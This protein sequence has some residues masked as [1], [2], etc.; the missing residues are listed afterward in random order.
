MNKF[1]KSIFS[2]RF[3]NL[4][5][6][7]IAVD[8][9]GG[10]IYYSFTTLLVKTDLEG[11]LVGTVDGLIGHLGCI[12]YNKEDGR[13][14]GSLE[15]KNDS[16]GR[17]IL[18]TLGMEGKFEDAFYC[19]IFDVERIDCVGM[20]A[21]RDGVMRAVYLSEVVADYNGI[22]EDSKP[23]RYACSGIDGTSFGVIPSDESGEQ[24]IFI[25]YGI[26]SDLERSDNDYQVILCY[27]ARDW[28]EGHSK[29]LSQ[30]DMHKSGPRQPLEKFFVY[31]GNTTFGIQNLEYDAYTGDFLAAVYKG[32]KPEFPN[33]SMY[34]IDGASAPRESVHRATGER[35]VEL[36]LKKEGLR[37][38]EIWGNNFP[39]GS[40]GIYS[41]GNGYYY[42]SESA[43]DGEGQ[44]TN[45]NL[46]RATGDAED[47]FEKI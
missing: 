41:F 7:G 24:R 42:F 33:Y 30:S 38:G 2:G 27:D 39:Y 1:P 23:H 32:K 36:S 22:G 21:E 28:W 12:A 6:Q 44:Y 5:C 31:T 20:S 18:A 34:V 16:I 3:G 19:A 17:G 8:E 37:S 26:Y 9:V 11:N 15:F 43:S 40:T 10:Y 4:H 47:P 25:C 14:Y 45:V 29:P 35:I 13:V 46:Y